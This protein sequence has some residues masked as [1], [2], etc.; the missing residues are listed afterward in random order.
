MKSP[1]APHGSSFGGV[2]ITHQSWV[3]VFLPGVMEYIQQMRGVLYDLHN[4]VQK[5]KLNVENITQL[6]EVAFARAIPGS[7]LQ[8]FTPPQ[9]HGAAVLSSPCRY[10][11]QIPCLKG[12]TRRKQHSWTWMGE[13]TH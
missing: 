8:G 11:Q 6:I 7:F 9:H 12:R 3:R 4:R 10:A 5:A 2:C 13:Q 1:G